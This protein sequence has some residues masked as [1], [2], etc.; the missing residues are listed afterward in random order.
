M[1]ALNDKDTTPFHLQLISNMMELDHYPLTRLIIENNMTK[2]EY[3]ELFQLLHS[4]NE[5]YELQKEEGFLDF[6]SL[7]IHFA[8]MLSE[9][10][11]PNATIYAIKK[12]GYYP[13]LLAVFIRIIEGEDGK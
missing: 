3:D 5:S 1:R 7:L 11:E 2:K 9:K 10:L 4:L 13:S 6:T 12:E 8:G